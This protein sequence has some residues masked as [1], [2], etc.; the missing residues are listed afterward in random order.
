[1]TQV[2]REATVDTTARITP[3]GKRLIY[4]SDTLGQRKL[5][6]RDLVSR[7]QKQLASTWRFN[8]FTSLVH[9]GTRVIFDGSSSAEKGVYALELG[10]GAPAL[11]LK[12]DVLFW[13]ASEDGRYFLTRPSPLTDFHAV[14]TET[15]KEFLFASHPSW[16]LLSPEFSHDGRW[17]AIHARNSEMTRQIFVLPFHEG[18]ETPQSEW[19]PITNGK[20][21]DR[22]PKWSPDDGLLYFVAD[23]DGARGIHAQRLDP[24][25]KR[26]VGPEFEVKMFRS[27]RRSMM[28]I[29]N[30]GHAAPAVAQDK[31]VFPLGEMTGN[32]WMT[33]LP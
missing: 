10:A 30:S 14:D 21:L 6:L 8:L 13:C 33:Q 11:L 15:G 24:A 16:N 4:F 25:T 5:F 28:Y 9:N 19:I 29:S 32:I 17:V 7:T 20:Q 26:P 23:R 18:R 27:T 2:T 22:D 12:A 3:D 31:I 1:M